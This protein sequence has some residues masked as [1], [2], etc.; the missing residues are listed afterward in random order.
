V[1]AEPLRQVSEWVQSYEHFWHHRLEQL[2][3]HLD[4]MEQR[5]DEQQDSAG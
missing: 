3:E 4:S 5:H 1:Q 2:A